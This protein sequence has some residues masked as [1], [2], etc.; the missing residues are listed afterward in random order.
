V[1][2]EQELDRRQK[3]ELDGEQDVEQDVDGGLE[4]NHR[5]RRVGDNKVY[6]LQ[7]GHMRC[8]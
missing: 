4:V 5:R 2:R 6:C 3:V 8:M 7:M 1:D